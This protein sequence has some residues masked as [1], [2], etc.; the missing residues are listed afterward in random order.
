MIV[1]V[2]SKQ[3]LARRAITMHVCRVLDH[4]QQAQCLLFPQVVQGNPGFLAPLASPQHLILLGSPSLPS[5]LEDQP[6]Q[7]HLEHLEFPIV[8]QQRDN[9]VIIAINITCQSC[10]NFH[11]DNHVTISITC[12]SCDFS[13]TCQSCD[14]FHHNNHVTISIT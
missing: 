10:D 4:V 2:Q 13:I 6:L 12:Q 5:D 1:V 14:N 3:Q 9:H 8:K 11:H 7:P